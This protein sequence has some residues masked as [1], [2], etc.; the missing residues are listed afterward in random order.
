MSSNPE[1]SIFEI[2]GSDINVK[3]IMEEIESRIKLRKIDLEELERISKLK[4]QPSSG[5]ARSFD[6]AF[7]AN[8]FQK[9][10]S[11]PSFSNPAYWFVRGPIKWFI[12][13]F[14]FLYSLFD[15]KISDNRIRAFYNVVH[16]LIELR[17]KCNR[18]EK[19]LEEV[20]KDYIE[21]RSSLG[22]NQYD[23]L[24]YDHGRIYQEFISK[25][26]KRILDLLNEN[27]K[28]LLLFA[29]P[30]SII[31]LLEHRRISFQL[32]TDNPDTFQ[33]IKKNYTANILYIQ[34]YREFKEY[35]LYDTIVLYGNACKLPGWLLQKL[36]L[37]L[38]TFTK[39]GTR[40]FF[41]FSNSAIT[42]HSPFQEVYL[43][44]VS[45]ELL[46]HFLKDFGFKN[47]VHH[48]VDEDE[49]ELFTFVKP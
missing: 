44:R 41:R 9:G 29:E 36:I 11:T 5:G 13:K 18:L 48:V 15:K 10:V 21:L 8:L 3:E 37:N 35:A 27:N 38:W 39:P 17:A 12:T 4:I 24:T 47:I 49:F 6:P 2:Q 22:K 14:V 33:F 26:N 28:L 46:I 30:D 45:P 16:E 25:S 19:K 20:T 1:K 23:V 31:Y 32:F 7:T 43:T 40:I 42:F 34:D